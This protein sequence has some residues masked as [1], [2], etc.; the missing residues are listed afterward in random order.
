MKHFLDQ[1]TH[2]D[3]GNTPMEEMWIDSAAKNFYDQ[4]N[5]FSFTKSWYSISG[6]AGLA[7]IKSSPPAVAPP[8]F[9]LARGQLRAPR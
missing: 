7:Q 9:P 5:E 8:G 4:D 6:G 1:A 3:L 2:L